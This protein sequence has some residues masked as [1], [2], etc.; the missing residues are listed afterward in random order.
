MWTRITVVA[1]AAQYVFKTCYY[2]NN[3]HT[4]ALSLEGTL[5]L[6]TAIVD[7]IIDIMIAVLNCHCIFTFNC[8]GRSGGF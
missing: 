3:L 7:L 2:S 4:H 5:K 1:G 8:V 6:Y